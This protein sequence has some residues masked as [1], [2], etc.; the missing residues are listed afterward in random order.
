MLFG[1]E[2]K[3][4]KSG[5]DTIAY[6][7]LELQ[8]KLLEQEYGYFSEPYPVK[9]EESE[10]DGKNKIKIALTTTL[11]EGLVNGKQFFYYSL[12]IK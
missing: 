6:C 3:E 11:L 2:I 10:I 9:K 1:Y 8:G 12:L 4:T 7:H 5:E